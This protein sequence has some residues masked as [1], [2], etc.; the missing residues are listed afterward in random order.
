MNPL[1]LT[2][3]LP[4]DSFH[5]LETALLSPLPSTS[6]LYLVAFTRIHPLPINKE[7]HEVNTPHFLT[8]SFIC[9]FYSETS[10]LTFLVR[11]ILFCSIFHVICTLV[12]CGKETT[13]VQI[14]QKN[15]K[16]KEK[17]LPKNE[18]I[19]GGKAHTNIWKFI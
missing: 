1:I 14:T 18:K 10:S 13:K 11:V 4:M 16:R 8:A 12:P 3:S 17:L 19:S 6:A 5:L 2:K 9:V 7:I 15:G